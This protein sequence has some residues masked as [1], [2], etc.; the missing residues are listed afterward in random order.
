[1]SRISQ[2]SLLL[3]GIL[4]AACGYGAAVGAAGEAPHSVPVIHCT[5]LFHPHVDPDDHFDL[6]TLYAMPEMDI[7]GIVL[8]QGRK[9]LE[10]PGRIPVSQMNRITGRSVAAVIGLATP[11]RSPA[12]KGL[13]QPQEFQQGVD[14]ILRTLRASPRPVCIATLGSVR[15]VVAAFNREPGLFRTNVAMVLAFIGEAS[16]ARFQEYNVGLDPQAYVGLM[17]S[18]LPLYWVP[19]FDG[20]LWQNRGHASFWR[21]SQRALLE[22]VAPEVIQYFIYALEKE[23]SEP[24]AFLSRPVEP[25]RQARLF[26]GTRNLW[27]A[28]ILGVM[29]GRDVVLEGGKW[30]SVLPGS[31]RRGTGA[32]RQP[33]FGF[34]EVDVS[35]DDTGAVRYGK[36]PDSHKVRRFEVRDPAH[37]EP[38]MVEATAALL[39]TLG[40]NANPSG[41]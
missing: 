21:A 12:D 38:G 25:E 30:T 11:L 19:C 37:Y 14:L 34:S 16:D 39:S 9:Q 1:M 29:S 40:R 33:L 27:C 15:D 10:R 28:A 26:A 24:A 32:V 3:A 23:T 8:D 31:G 22:R 20:G 18:G 5:D 6:A 36:G 2:L 4:G 41:R 17:R 35:V 7:K 13:E